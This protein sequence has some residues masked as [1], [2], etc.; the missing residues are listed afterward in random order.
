MYNSKFNSNFQ[1]KAK[2]YLNEVK[3]KQSLSKYNN[4][5]D[6]NSMKN[7]IDQIHSTIKFKI[8]NVRSL[9]I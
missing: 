5:K 8:D 9:L 7:Y 2:K 4:K 6:Y 3:L 1:I